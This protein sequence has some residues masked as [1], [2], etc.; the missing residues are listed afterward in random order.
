MGISTSAAREQYGDVSSK[1]CL[2]LDID[3]RA[4]SAD[5]IRRR[6]DAVAAIVAATRVPSDDDTVERAQAEAQMKARAQ[7]QSP[8]QV[9]EAAI[10]GLKKSE[11]VGACPL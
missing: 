4:V 8:A 2:W 6:A 10:A 3:E 9:R 5:I 11:E 7:A 1:A